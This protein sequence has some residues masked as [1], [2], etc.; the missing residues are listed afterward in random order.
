[1]KY[2]KIAE[3]SRAAEIAT[4]YYSIHLMSKRDTEQISAI[5]REAFPDQWRPPSS[6]QN[7]LRNEMI[8]YII[9]C[10]D[11]KTVSTPEA[12]LEEIPTG[13]IPSIR[14]WFAHSTAGREAATP[15]DRFI[16]GYASVWVITD[17]AHIT[18][19]A[20]RRQY[21]RQGIG[22]LL[23][24][25]TVEQAREMGADTLTLEVRVSNTGAQALYSKYDFAE[26]GLRRGYYTDNHEDGLIMTTASINSTSFQ[27]HFQQLKQEHARRWGLDYSHPGKG[28]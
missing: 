8:R 9:A 26:A 14:Q 24:I 16:T 25:N 17:E 19:I 2:A 7:D 22:E 23:L 21:Q 1:M 11:S 3:Q 18:N 20:V 12:A 28:G 4:L 10:D 27:K 6:Y 5:D 13:I 15:G